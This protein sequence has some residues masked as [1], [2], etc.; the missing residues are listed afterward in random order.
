MKRFL[1]AGN[2]APRGRGFH[3]GVMHG[4]KTTKGKEECKSEK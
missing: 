4:Q 1:L 3:D 2:A